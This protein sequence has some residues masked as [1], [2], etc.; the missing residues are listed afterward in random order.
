[1]KISMGRRAA[2]FGCAIVLSTLDLQ[3]QESSPSPTPAQIEVSPPHQ[4]TS[5]GQL[6]PSFRIPLP[7][8]LPAG[9]L[10]TQIEQR[11]FT[12]SGRFYP[13]AQGSGCFKDAPGV[14]LESPQVSVVGGKLVLKTHLAGRVSGPLF[15]HPTISSDLTI[16][17]VP[18]VDNNVLRL[19]Q[20]I[21]ETD[22][23]SLLFKLGAGKFRERA[24]NELE[25]KVRYD[26]SPQLDNARSKINARVPFQ[27]GQRCLG[28]EL[29]NLIVKS[30][31]PV[32]TPQGVEI[33]FEA[34]VGLTSGSSCNRA[35]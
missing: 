33:T 20:I 8:L 2:I 3:G 27:W 26:L 34:A 4:E 17:A 28:V 7:I 14:Y 10:Q 13:C 35:N 16:Y 1:M 11:L 31:V 32:E 25:N 12:E 24:I 21:L 18:V 9:E 23:S 19:D 29:G 30:V 22:S 5:P 15:S 6:S